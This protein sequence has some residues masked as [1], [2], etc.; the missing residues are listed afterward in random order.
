VARWQRYAAPGASFKVAVN[1]SA[2]QLEVGLP[3]QVRDVLAVNRLPGSALTLEMTE[4]VL[5]ERTDEVVELLRRIKTLG[6][7][8][9]VDDFGTGYSSLSY[10]SRFPVDILKVDKSFVAHL[11]QEDGQGELVRT[12]VRLGDSLR[13]DT[14]AEG[15]ETAEQRAALEAMGCGFGQGFLFA[16]PVPADE[17]D[18]LLASEHPAT[19]AATATATRS[20]A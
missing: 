8:L 14:V 20:P 15:I 16:R 1:V 5:M 4:S 2:R 17:I 12:I 11:G 19:A 18:A 3:R 6:V 10:L 13:L 7:R 9:A